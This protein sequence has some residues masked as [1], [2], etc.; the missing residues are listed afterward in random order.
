LTKIDHESSKATKK[1]NPSNKATTR[2]DQLKK[3]AKNLDELNKVEKILNESNKGAK[4]LDGSN[5]AT[6]KPNEL[7][8]TTQKLNA[9]I[10]SDKMRNMKLCDA[11]NNQKIH[12]AHLFDKADNTNRMNT[13]P[14]PV[15]DMQGT[16]NRRIARPQLLRHISDHTTVQIKATINRVAGFTRIRKETRIGTEQ[17]Q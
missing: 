16:L 6:K 3:E 15:A 4:K 11:S 1:M 10:A 13:L 14:F 2:P 7:N 5:E 8:R 9:S 17:L 12:S